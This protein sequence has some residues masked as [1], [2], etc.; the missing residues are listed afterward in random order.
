MEIVVTFAEKVDFVNGQ[1]GERVEGTRVQYTFPE[2][3]QEENMEGYP[4]FKDWLDVR[5]FGQCVKVPGRYTARVVKTPG[6]D[7]K[8]QDKIKGLEYL[9]EVVWQF[10]AKAD[11]K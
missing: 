9:G 2:K 8:P 1:T 4:L 10:T 7:G 5:E 11:G 3:V 6:K